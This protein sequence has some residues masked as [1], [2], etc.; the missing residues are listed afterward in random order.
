MFTGCVVYVRPDRPM[1]PPGPVVEEPVYEEPVAE[2]PVI[3]GP[4][5]VVIDVEPDPIYRVYVYD[6]GFPP[7]IYF[8]DGFYYYSGY[9]YEHDIFI[10]R[11]VTVNIREHRYIDVD[12]N[13]RLGR[14]M[15]QRQHEEY[16][17]TGGRHTVQPQR[18]RPTVN[19]S[20]PKPGDRN[21]GGD[22]RERQ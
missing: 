17:R 21:G 15:E 1:P 22:D 5:V 6:P 7:G 16:S 8:Y 19:H 4:G 11:Y 10:N 3:E 18:Q 9:R 13:R 12:E 14:A 20:S 2:G